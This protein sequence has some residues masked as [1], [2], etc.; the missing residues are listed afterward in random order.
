MGWL[1]WL[2]PAHEHVYTRMWNSRSFRCEC[3]EVISGDDLFLLDN[4]LGRMWRENYPR[5]DWGAKDF[6]FDMELPADAIFRPG[7]GG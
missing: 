5:P 3:G 4:A 7:R 1:D 2:F 6:V